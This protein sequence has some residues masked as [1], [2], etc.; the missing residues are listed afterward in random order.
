MS[1]CIKWIAPCYSWIFIGKNSHM[2]AKTI[3][4]GDL[5]LSQFAEQ[6][7]AA[8]GRRNWM[9][10]IGL[11]SAGI[12]PDLPHA[13]FT[14]QSFGNTTIQ[15]VFRLVSYLPWEALEADRIN[16]RHTGSHFKPID[17]SH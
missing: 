2:N 6:L 17:I 9:A 1:L 3:S 12:K 15:V 10:S 8:D 16:L 5:C 7:G 14:R 11:C 4:F 13:Q